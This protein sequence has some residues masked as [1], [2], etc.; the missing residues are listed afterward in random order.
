MADASSPSRRGSQ[1]LD[2]DASPGAYSDHLSTST[3]GSRSGGFDEPAPVQFGR[4]WILGGGLFLPKAVALSTVEVTDGAGVRSFV[5][6]HKGDR[7]LQRWAS[8]GASGKGL[9]SQVRIF[10][11]MQ[12]EALRKRDERT[13]AFTG[14]EAA[15]V[16]AG[17]GTRNAPAGADS[18]RSA[19]A[20]LGLD[21]LEDVGGEATRVQ[22]KCAMKNSRQKGV[23]CSLQQLPPVLT[24]TL[25]LQGGAAREFLSLTP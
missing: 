1:P 13:R 10:S 25:P 17:G 20:A 19:V 3:G 22:R 5:S 7:A 18:R 14:S 4:G 21:D 2:S 16:S 6:L 23:I 12:R 24:L 15:P 8:D 11:R 9:F